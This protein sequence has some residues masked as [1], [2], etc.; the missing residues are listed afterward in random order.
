MSWVNVWQQAASRQSNL[1]GSA[2][3]SR[4]WFD[5][6]FTLFHWRQVAEWVV[7]VEVVEAG[8]PAK[9]QP[10]SWLIVVGTSLAMPGVARKDIIDQPIII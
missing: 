2:V 8:R 1:I 5:W 7:R 9:Q 10:A 4:V 3:A 6:I